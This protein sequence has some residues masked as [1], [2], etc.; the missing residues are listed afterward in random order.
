MDFLYNLSNKIDNIN[1]QPHTMR[2]IMI[3]ISKPNTFF[4]GYPI[5][6]IFC[7]NKG[8]NELL[9]ILLDNKQLYNTIC[10]LPHVKNSDVK[11]MINKIIKS[12]KTRVCTV[13]K[14]NIITIY[15]EY[16]EFGKKYMK[17]CNIPDALMCVV[18]H[19]HKT[20]MILDNVLQYKSM[21]KNH[22]G[23]S[24]FNTYELT[25]NKC[26]IPKEGMIEF[27]SCSTAVRSNFSYSTKYQANIWLRVLN[28]KEIIVC[29][30]VHRMDDLK[31]RISYI[32][33]M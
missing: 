15:N 8:N 13:V 12:K 1:T 18:I 24:I 9:E 5:F 19:S 11:Y 25:D 32:C 4:E 17:L 33:D 2:V 22:T 21:S 20:K 6:V 16:K 7:K 10:N 27:I 23:T 28:K 31:E 14:G 3:V 29:D 26:V 30:N